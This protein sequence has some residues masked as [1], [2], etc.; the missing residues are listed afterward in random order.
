[1]EAYV[2]IG[3]SFNL[4]LRH[5]LLI[6]ED[7]H[8]T[9]ATLHDVLPQAEGAPL[10]AAARPLSLA[11]LRRLSQGL[12]ASV[13]PELLPPSVLARTSE[14]MV[15]WL[16][17]SCRILFFGEADKRARKLNG[18][19][20]PQP[21][22]VFKVRGRELFVRVLNSNARP[23]A[24][25][26]LKTTP[27]WNVAQA[28]G[29]VCLGTVRTPDN[30]SVDSMPSWESAFFQS[31]FT[32]PWGAARLTSYPGGFTGLWQTLRGKKSFPT[33]YLVDARQTL[34]EFITQDC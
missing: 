29:R 33:R 17:A 23:D 5:A 30:V 6:Y 19:M 10:L 1:M 14:M 34:R 22:L 18:F 16:P 20:F 32:H 28:S 12:G 31:E 13:A 2:Q 9:F 11:F 7:Q 25:A 3:E 15:W 27:Y 24:D 8:Q 26:R 21:P 4:Q